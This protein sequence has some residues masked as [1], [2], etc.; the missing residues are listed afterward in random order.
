M[1]LHFSCW[2]P[3]PEALYVDAFMGDWSKEF[4]YAF[5]PF[6]LVGRT[7]QKCI[8]ERVMGVLITPRWA[9]QAWFTLLRRYIL[10]KP[11]YFTVYS[12]ELFLPFNS[13]TKI[14][15]MVP[16]R[17]QAVMVDCR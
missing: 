3:D 16:L 4:I 17:M 13:E 15:P 12:D 8:T 11:Y 6:A 10:G 14:H 5:P 7:L 9:G 1:C 2:Q